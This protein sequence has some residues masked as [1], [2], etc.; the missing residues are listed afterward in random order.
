[1]SQRCAFLSIFT[2][3]L[4]LTF[5]PIPTVTLQTISLTATR[6]V[7]SALQGPLTVCKCSKSKDPN[8]GPSPQGC[9][10]CFPSPLLLQAPC[11]TSPTGLGAALGFPPTWPTDSSRPQAAARPSLQPL[12]LPYLSSNKSGEDQRL[13][14][15]P[16][17]NSWQGWKVNQAQSSPCVRPHPWTIWFPLGTVQDFVW[18]K[19]D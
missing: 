17:V 5:L 18:Q 13:S 14:L 7:C 3:A 15:G 2:A 10:G 9:T 16:T 11:S 4:P 12:T 1:M 19:E 6:D 8:S